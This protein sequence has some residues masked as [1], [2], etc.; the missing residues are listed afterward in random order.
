M[1]EGIANADGSKTEITP[2][3]VEAVSTAILAGLE[4][5]DSDRFF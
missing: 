1:S 4:E 2:E 3:M 5:S